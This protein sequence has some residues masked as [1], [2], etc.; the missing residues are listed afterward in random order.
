[1]K[2]EEQ[3]LPRRTKENATV[4]PPLI[5]MVV[6]VFSVGRRPATLETYQSASSRPTRGGFSLLHDPFRNDRQSRQA[7]EQGNI[8]VISFSCLQ[9]ETSVYYVHAPCSFDHALYFLQHPMRQLCSPAC[10]FAELSS[11]ILSFSP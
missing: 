11:G 1:M 3:Q 2:I 5:D 7:R 9:L 10:S 8:F 6:C 4:R